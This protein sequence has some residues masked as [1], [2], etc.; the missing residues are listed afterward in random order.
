MARYKKSDIDILSK[1]DV[2][3]L[4]DFQRLPAT[5]QWQVVD[6]IRLMSTDAKLAQQ[7][8]EIAEARYRQF[9]AVAKKR[10]ARKRG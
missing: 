10:P 3:T 4:H 9:Q 7:D 2:M 1:L 8:R 6:L 5:L